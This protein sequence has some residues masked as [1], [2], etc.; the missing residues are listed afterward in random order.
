MSDIEWLDALFALVAGLAFFVAIAPIVHYSRFGHRERRQEVVEY[1]KSTDIQRYYDAFYPA[2][3]DS[4]SRGLEEFAQFYDQRFGWPSYRLSLIAYVLALIVSFLWIISAVLKQQPIHGIDLR[5]A[6]YA[7]GGAYVWVVF[8]L[9][10]RFARRDIVP[11]RLYTYAVRFIVIIPIAYV[12]SGALNE[13]AAP[14]ALIALRSFPTDTLYRLMRRQ[15]AKALNL[16]DEGPQALRYELE[17][18]QGVNTSKAERFSDAGVDSIVELAFQDPIQLTMRTNFGFRFV[19]DVMSQAVLYVYLR[20][21]EAPSRYAVRSSMD[22]DQ[23]FKD[24]Y[25]IDEDK[26]PKEQK[27]AQKRAQAVVEALAHDLKMAP[28]ILLKI[29]DDA[30]GDPANRFLSGLPF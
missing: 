22:A 27:E 24:F 17:V 12:I 30:R 1:F 10:L 15:G 18:L 7:L 25:G 29:L 23:L 14:Y 9:L 3:P 26:D 4:K 2:R 28:P 5:I 16:A 20:N 13:R 6:A 11:T 19:M 21:L 8:D